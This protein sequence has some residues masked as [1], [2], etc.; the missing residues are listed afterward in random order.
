[1]RTAIVDGCITFTSTQIPGGILITDPIVLMSKICVENPS[2]TNRV[3]EP[4][5]SA[6]HCVQD[7]CACAPLLSEADD[8]RKKILSRVLLSILVRLIARRSVTPLE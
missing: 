5:S 6:N 8:T 1:V 4:F 7:L 3:A 2:A